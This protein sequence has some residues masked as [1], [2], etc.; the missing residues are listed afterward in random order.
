[1]GEIPALKIKVDGQRR[2]KTEMTQNPLLAS[3]MKPGQLGLRF[4]FRFICQMKL[5]LEIHPSKLGRSSS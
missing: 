3:K 1:M 4:L 2:R 5:A